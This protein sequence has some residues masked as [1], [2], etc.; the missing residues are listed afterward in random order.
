MRDTFQEQAVWKQIAPSRVLVF[1]VLK[2][3]KLLIEGIPAHILFTSNYIIM[4]Y[5]GTSPGKE[6]IRGE[7]GDTRIASPG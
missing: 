6:R 2:P 5:C 4:G 3:S 1:L 7:T